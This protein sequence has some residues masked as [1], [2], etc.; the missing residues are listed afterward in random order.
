M[1]RP[2]PRADCRRC[3]YYDPPS[4]GLSRGWCRARDETVIRLVGRC[5]AYEG[6]PLEPESAEEED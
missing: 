1:P 2:A 3:T 5:D 4:H 6:P